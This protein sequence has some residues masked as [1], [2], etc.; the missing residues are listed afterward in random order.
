[1]VLNFCSH[2]PVIVLLI[3]EKHC[4]DEELLFIMSYLLKRYSMIKKY[5]HDFTNKFIKF[6]NL[7]KFE[8]YFS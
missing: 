7:V 8:R 4:A 1:M 6:P 2:L 3:S 5:L